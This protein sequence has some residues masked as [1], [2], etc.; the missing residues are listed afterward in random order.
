M[1]NYKVEWKETAIITR[2]AIIE[3]ESKDTAIDLVL[4]G[5]RSTKEVTG[6]VD[7]SDYHSFKANLEED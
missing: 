4:G 7:I 3:A 1:P 5:D 6:K 2:S